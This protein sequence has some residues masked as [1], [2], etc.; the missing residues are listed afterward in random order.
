MAEWRRSGKSNESG[1]L[2]LDNCANNCSIQKFKESP[3]QYPS[4]PTLRTQIMF[5]GRYRYWGVEESQTYRT[6]FQRWITFST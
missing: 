1:K 5:E 2:N 3:K 6:I 4:L